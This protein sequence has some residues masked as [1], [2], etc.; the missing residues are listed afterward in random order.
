MRR[1]RQTVGSR[2]RADPMELLLQS[3]VDFVRVRAVYK[4]RQQ[5]E[6]TLKLW[7]MEAKYT[8][9]VCWDMQK[10]S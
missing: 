4:Q 2:A 1:L 6:K 10:L 8:L 7:W 5:Q 3:R 9:Q